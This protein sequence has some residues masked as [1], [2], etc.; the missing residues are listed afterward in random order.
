MRKLIIFVLYAAVALRA[1]SAVEEVKIVRTFTDGSKSE[2]VQK[3]EKKGDGIYR[4]HIPYNMAWKYNYKY[5]QHIDVK[6]GD[7]SAKKGDEG[8]WVCSDGRL[9]LF[10]KD[11]GLLME[12]RNPMPIYGVKKGDEAFV[13]I[14]KGLKY[15]FST[16]VE[17]KDGNYEV[18]PRF[19]IKEIGTKPYE[20]IIIDYVCFKGK[21]ANYSSMGK[22][23]RKYQLDRGEVKPLKE[24]VIGNPRLK[25]TAE[26]IFMK[27]MMASFMRDSEVGLNRGDH[28]KPEDDPPIQ[29][30]RDFDNMKEVLKKMKS[31]GIDK[32]DIVLTNWNWRSNGRN[33][34]CSVAEPELGGNAK[35]KEL[36]ALGKELG[37]QIIPHILH[38]E[39]YTISPAFCKDDIAIDAEGKYRGYTG[40]GGK[41]FNPCFIQVYRKHILDNYDRMQKLGFNGP[42]HIDVTSCITP[43]SCFNIDHFATRKDTGEYMNKVG[44]L[45][46][47]FFGGWTSEGPCDQVANTLDYALYVSAYPSYVGAAHPLMDRCIP[48]W[49]IAYHG[50][51]LSNPFASTIDYNCR[52]RPAKGGWGPTTSFTPETRR[53]KF[54]E[55]GGRL[56]YYW[57]LNS[58]KNFPDVKQAYDEYQPLKYLQYEFMDFHGEIAKDVFVTKYSDGSE[59]VTNYSDKEYNYKGKGIVK[60]MDY[61]LFKA[62][63]AKN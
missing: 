59:I 40:M 41:G 56:T 36:T 35:C 17:V 53:L 21:D 28:W 32:A 29:K 7:A 10:N 47:A 52:T 54:V 11:S 13:G 14:I 34:I 6:C 57:N 1:F 18:Y 27:F 60:S 39:N 19:H 48:L 55:F 49:Q 37:Y 38:T 44:M 43:Y 42:I 50:I 46:D 51:I 24:R 45:G 33:P 3:L 58:D 31:M 22:A 61:K 2:S 12:R 4:L 5:V 62:P 20:D 26:A 9:G 15:E 63:T 25:Y 16:V 30:Y 8:Y 23:Y